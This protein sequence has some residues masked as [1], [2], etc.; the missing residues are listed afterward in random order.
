M[1]EVDHEVM[2]LGERRPFKTQ[3]EQ[4]VEPVPA[5]PEATPI[6]EAVVEKVQ[7]VVANEAPTGGAFWDN[8]TEDQTTM[9]SRSRACVWLSRSSAMAQ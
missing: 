1:S 2:L 5:E 6:Q 4:P 7:E 3:S 8:I 9:S